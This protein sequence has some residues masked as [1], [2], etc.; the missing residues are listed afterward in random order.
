[1]CRSHPPSAKFRND[2]ETSFF[3]PDA[4]RL[5]GRCSVAE[6]EKSSLKMAAEKVDIFDQKIYNK[7][8]M[9]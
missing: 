2:P 5:T 3:G 1:M 6:H 7:N 4:R 9:S 8:R